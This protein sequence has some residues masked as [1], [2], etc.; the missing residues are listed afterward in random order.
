MA[1]YQYL[2]C[3]PLLSWRYPMTFSIG[4][5]CWGWIS[6]WPEKIFS[7]ISGFGRILR[8]S[9]NCLRMSGDWLA[10]VNLRS[11]SPLKTFFR[12]YWPFTSL[13]IPA[14]LGATAR[15]Y[16]SEFR[17]F[18]FICLIRA[19][20]PLCISVCCI[21]LSPTQFLFFHFWLLQPLIIWEMLF[22]LLWWLL[23]IFYKPGMPHVK[24]FLL[25]GEWVWC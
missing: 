5:L 22:L 21:S 2:Y 18:P 15:V 6:Y 10:Y 9:N 4:S 20:T 3:T 7:V 13:Q 12:L 14:I 11:F 19:A 17:I 8:S 1:D 24:L 16:P 23:Y 25:L